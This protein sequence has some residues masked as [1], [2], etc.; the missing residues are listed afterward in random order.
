[1]P[2]KEKKQAA[3][4]ISNAE[5]G[6]WMLLQKKVGTGRISN[7]VEGDWMQTGEKKQKKK[8]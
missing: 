3:G 2:K 7:A 5:E 6:D 1:M 8:R 4:R